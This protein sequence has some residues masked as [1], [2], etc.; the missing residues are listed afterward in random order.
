MLGAVA[1]QGGVG[2]ERGAGRVLQSG[3]EVVRDGELLLQV[4]GGHLEGGE[5]VTLDTRA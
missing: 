4:T 5:L 1:G 2:V 3:H